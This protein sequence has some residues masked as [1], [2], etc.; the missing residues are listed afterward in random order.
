MVAH[1]SVS[2]EE[3]IYSNF[4][5]LE[6]EDRFPF[7]DVKVCPYKEINTSEGWERQRDCEAKMLISLAKTVLNMNTTGKVE[8]Y[9]KYEP[10]LGC[11]HY[12][13]QFL[14][15]FK[16]IDIDIY[17]EYPYPDPK[18]YENFVKKQ[19]LKIWKAS[20]KERL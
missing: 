8:L 3:N 6:T 16:N 7:T 14:N 1:S 15:I 9:T 2:K 19:T 20:E 13:I 4:F 18:N 17:W 5:V 10:C 12:F 11:D